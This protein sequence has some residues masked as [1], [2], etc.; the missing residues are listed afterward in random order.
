M[1]DPLAWIDAEA[2]DR[3]N[4]GLER[5]LRVFGATTSGGTAT[6]GG[7]PIPF[8]LNDYLGLAND[9]RVVAAAVRE[10]EAGG[11]GAGLRRRTHGG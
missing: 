7:E 8:S 1:N 10:A 4:R 9:P 3:L 2:R 11:W 5:R 6:E